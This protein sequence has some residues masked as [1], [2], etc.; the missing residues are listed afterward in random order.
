IEH[1]IPDRLGMLDRGRGRECRIQTAA[2]RQYYREHGPV[3]LRL[4]VSIVSMVSLRAARP[5]IAA[6]VL[7]LAA[8]PAIQAQPI[9]GQIDTFENGTVM[10]WATGLS[11]SDPIN[12]AT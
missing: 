7:A 10:N 6:F 9:G 12:V 8:V 5:F 11:P 3:I 4:G 2:G 1:A